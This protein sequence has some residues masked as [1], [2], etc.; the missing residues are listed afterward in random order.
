MSQL[1]IYSTYKKLYYGILL[2]NDYMNIA[3]I[4]MLL[5]IVH[6]AVDIHTV[7][8][9]IQILHYHDVHLTHNIPL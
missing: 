9:Y 1:C 4:F 5:Y 7:T 2:S 6:V 3:E 8:Y